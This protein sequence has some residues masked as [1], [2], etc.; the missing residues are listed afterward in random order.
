MDLRIVGAAVVIVVVLIAAAL[1]FTQQSTSGGQ[2]QTTTT[3]TGGVGATTTTQGGGGG[4]STQT[5]QPSGGVVGNQSLANTT[6]TSTTT[7]TSVPKPLVKA[8]LRAIEPTET[9]SRQGIVLIIHASVNITSSIPLKIKMFY[10]DNLQPGKTT[11]PL[12]Q[13]L[14]QYFDPP[15]KTPIKFTI[16]APLTQDMPKSIIQQ[17]QKG[18]THTLTVVYIY[19]GKTYTETINVTVT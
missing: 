12:V 18:T 10:F 11:N 8:S 9:Q 15:R 7:T 4:A 6:T 14:F 13:Y 16:D 3:P 19:N 5:S 2:A 1:Y 17:W